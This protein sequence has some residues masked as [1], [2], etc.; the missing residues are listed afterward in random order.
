M[1]TRFLLALGLLIA[2]AGP[3]TAEPQSWAAIKRKLP[4]TAIAVIGVDVAAVQNHAAF[5]KVWSEALLKGRV[6]QASLDAVKAG[7][8]IDAMAAVVDA[9]VVIGTADAAIMVLALKGVDQA[10]FL[11]C[12]QAALADHG[13][14]VL[15]AKKKGKLV[16]Y[17]ID[18]KDPFYL[19]WIGPGVVAFA[20]GA[21]DK[22][23]LE[24]MIG[25]KGVRG[26]LAGALGK[27]SRTAPVW[28]AFAEATPRALEDR[29]G[30]E[31]SLTAAFGT[32]TL[33]GGTLDLAATSVVGSAAEATRFAQLVDTMLPV[34]TK[35][36]A[37]QLPGLAA[38][39]ATFKAT[40]TAAEMTVTGSIS[41]ASLASVTQL[42]AQMAG[43]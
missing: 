4:A 6:D 1:R 15:A 38:D 3:A 36:V 23:A 7:C 21:A 16:E 18:G 20:G 17:T 12:G 31:V 26:A 14:G 41:E 19:A 11:R 42:G 37:K 33:S 24:K 8:G 5:Q 9:T 22:K 40:A 10:T 27:V 34:A 30:V 29:L 32:I 28:F 39:L 35:Q 25:G 2:L 13:G 43:P